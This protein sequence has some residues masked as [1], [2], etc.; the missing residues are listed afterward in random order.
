MWDGILSPSLYL[1]TLLLDKILNNY[2]KNL[3]YFYYLVIGINQLK[4]RFSFGVCYNLFYYINLCS[5][6]NDIYIDCG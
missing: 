5:Y 3:F 2:Y 4:M 6:L 1:R